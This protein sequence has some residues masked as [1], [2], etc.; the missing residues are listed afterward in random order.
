MSKPLRLVI[1]LCLIGSGLAL[2]LACGRRAAEPG[3]ALRAEPAT[4]ASLV[5]AGAQFADRDLLGA[6]ELRKT[7]DPSFESVAAYLPA[8]A[9][10]REA[11]GVKHHPH[12]I[13][14]R[15]DGAL[16]LNDDASEAP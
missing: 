13:G 16:E 9:K 3:A 4:G 12:E 15:P 6:L 1:G 11:V 10:P 8:L 7:E 14:V 2:S 5:P